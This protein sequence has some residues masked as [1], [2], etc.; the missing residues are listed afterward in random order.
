MA[1]SAAL[2]AV[3]ILFYGYFSLSIGRSISIVHIV[4]I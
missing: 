2:A 3:S 1:N 4:I